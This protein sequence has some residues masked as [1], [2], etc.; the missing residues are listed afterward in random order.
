MI[1]LAAA[2]AL[3]DLCAA[4]PEPAAARDPADSAAYTTIGDDAVAG[5]DAR[6]AMIAYQKA[7]AL[8]PDN[9][10]AKTALAALC[11]DAAD[12]G[13][14]SEGAALLDAITRYRAGEH[15]AAS[16][17]LREIAG[18]RGEAA[19]GAHFFLGLIALD[20]HDTGTAIRELEQAREDPDYRALATSL[21]RLA[22]RD[23]ALAI[24]LLVE[25]EL[26]TNPQLLPGTPPSGAVTGAPSVDEDLLTAATIT[27]RP[28]SWLAVHNAIAW[29]NQRR[30]SPLDFVSDTLRVTAELAGHRDR[31]AIRYDFDYDLLD[32]TRYLLAHRAGASYRREWPRLALVASYSLRRR[33]FARDA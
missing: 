16:A 26:D 9:A 31:V 12:S 22:H 1:L 18:S 23:G 24:S 32:G 11:R 7:I 25:P 27:A 29:R 20:K 28:W 21:L 15:A 4:A 30:L 33:D 3:A 5:G 8:D 10:R 14:G 13:E 19:P 2:A 6:T 17:A